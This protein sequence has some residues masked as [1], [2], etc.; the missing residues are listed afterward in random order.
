MDHIHVLITV[1][2]GPPTRP[3]TKE[4]LHGY[5]LH[6]HPYF[7]TEIQLLPHTDVCSNA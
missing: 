7:T 5:L 3:R 2:P 1:S 4:V 6:R